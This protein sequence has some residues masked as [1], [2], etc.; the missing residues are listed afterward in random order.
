M[1][2]KKKTTFSIGIVLLAML[3]GILAG[4]MTAPKLDAKYWKQQEM[5]SA[6]SQRINTMLY[7]IDNYY[8]DKVDYDSLTDQM[9]NSLLSTLDPHSAYLTPSAYEQESETMSGHFEG[10]GLTLYYIGDTVYALHA[11]AGAP[12]AKAGLR[13][14]D[15]IIRVDTTTVSGA[16]MTA[17]PQSVVNLI[18]GPRYSTVELTVQRQG[19]EK[20]H[21]F[22]VR[23]DVIHNTSV[24]AHVMLDNKTGY[25]RISSFGSIT[26]TEFHAALLELQNENMKHLVLDLRGNGG[27]SLETAIGVCDELLPKGDLIV[28]TQGEHARRSNIYATSGGLFEENRLTVLID[29]ESASASEI[30]AGAVQDNDRGTIVGH[31]SFGKGL[32]QRQFPLPGGAAAM[33]TVARYY[34][35]SGRC[36]QRPYDMG[37]DEY[38]RQYIT[39]I[40]QNYVA[41]DSILDAEYDTTQ[42]FLTKKGRKVYGGGGIRPDIMLP[43]FSDTNLIYYNQLIGHRVLEEHM[44]QQLFEHYDQIISRY[45]TVEQFVKNY[46]VDDATWQSILALADKKKITRRTAGINKYGEAIRNRYKANLANAIYGENAYYKIALTGDIELQNALEKLKIKK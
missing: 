45:P 11:I 22:K 35:P 19:S 18:R 12:A 8:V 27:G 9:M 23:R 26:A 17:Q 31:R 10:I 40:I 29:E 1:T 6:M 41:A 21:T 14:G 15:R 5:E 32:V 39:R 20:L 7:L 30:V 24:P 37:T 36:I 13:A 3:L 38:Y 25:I 33:L 42:T 16:G 34:T 2:K 4:V 28:Y 44:F 46:Q 43:Y